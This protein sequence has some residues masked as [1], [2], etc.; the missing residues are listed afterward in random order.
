MTTHAVQRSDW[1][2]IFKRAQETQSLEETLSPSLVC[3]HAELRL[4]A[5]DGTAD[6]L[7]I[8]FKWR[9]T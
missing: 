9:T 3:A 7:N 4:L 5:F 8:F 2:Y 6:Q 1:Y